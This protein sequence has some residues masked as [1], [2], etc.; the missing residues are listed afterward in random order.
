MTLVARTP[1]PNRRQAWSMPNSK[2]MF[3]RAYSSAA[4]D[5]QRLRSWMPYF[6]PRIS[7][8]IRSRRP[9]ALSTFSGAKRAWKPKKITQKAIAC[10]IGS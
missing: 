10:R 2:G 7:S 4:E 1:G 5:L 8:T 9:A 3:M 6:E